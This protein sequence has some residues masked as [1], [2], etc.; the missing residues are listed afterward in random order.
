MPR[1]RDNCR[2]AGLRQ[3]PIFRVTTRRRSW[4]PRATPAWWCTHG[5]R[6]PLRKFWDMLCAHLPLLSPTPQLVTFAFRGCSGATCFPST[7]FRR[8]TRAECHPLDYRAHQIH[9][10]QNWVSTKVF[11]VFASCRDRYCGRFISQWPRGTEAGSF[12]HT[13]LVGYGPL[14]KHTVNHSRSAPGSPVGKE[15]N[16]LPS[17]NSSSA[18][19]FVV[20]PGT[21]SSFRLSP[22][23]RAS[24]A[25]W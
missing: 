1:P 15:S 2:R 18:S 13:S 23:G 14:W 20:E 8:F 3:P 10:L 5:G 21:A 25:D 7:V 22:T 17:P 24:C 12:T 6:R 16:S 11:K 9:T 4:A 19:T